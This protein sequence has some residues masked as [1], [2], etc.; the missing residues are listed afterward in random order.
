MVFFTL[1]ARLSLGIFWVRECIETLSIM[2][3]Q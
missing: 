2:S 1:L 3:A